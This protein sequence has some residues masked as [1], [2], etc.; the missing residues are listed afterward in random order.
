MSYRNQQIRFCTS[1][2]GTSIAYATCGAGP[3]L[4]WVQHWMHHLK[5]DLDNVIWR[6]WLE[7]LARHHTLVRFDWRG[8]GL[9]DRN[10]VDFAF[11]NVVDDLE[12]VID[13]AGI[14]RFALFGMAGAGSGIAMSYAVRHPERVARLVLHEPHTMGRMVGSLA[15]EA[16]QEADAR[17]KVIELD[18]IIIRRL[19]ANSLARSTFQRPM[20]IKFVR[21]MI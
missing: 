7:L 11:E 18:G 17:L 3:P 9:S 13:A 19:M 20:R 16:V 14:E 5:F 4:V 6:P 1:R 21:I 15:L 2:D 12:A 8:C 10:G